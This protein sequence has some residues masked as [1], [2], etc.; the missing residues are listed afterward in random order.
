M[1]EIVTQRVINVKLHCAVA[2]SLHPEGIASSIVNWYAWRVHVLVRLQRQ[3]DVSG[4][5]MLAALR[6]EL[7]A[8]PA[9]PDSPYEPDDSNSVLNPFAVP[10]RLRIP[11]GVLSFFSTTTVFGTPVDVTLSELAIEAFLPADPQTAT[12]LR[13]YA[14]SQSPAGEMPTP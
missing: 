7:C 13:A 10:L 11:L 9:P 1:H 5:E 12:A 3:I 4:D 6:D 14:E 8:Y 2:L